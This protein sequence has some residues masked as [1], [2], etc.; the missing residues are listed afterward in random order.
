MIVKE[1]QKAG[2]VE[3]EV[4]RGGTPQVEMQMASLII[5]Q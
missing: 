1:L 2:W 5:G 3:A 4:H